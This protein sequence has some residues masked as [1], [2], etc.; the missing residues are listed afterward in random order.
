VETAQRKVALIVA[1]GKPHMGLSI[2][3]RLTNA[4]HDVFLVGENIDPGL[5]DEGAAVTFRLTWRGLDADGGKICRQP[6]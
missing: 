3:T 1:N 5:C 2:A 6:E 4:G